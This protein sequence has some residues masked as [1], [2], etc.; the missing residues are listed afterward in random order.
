MDT[1]WA[2]AAAQLLAATLDFQLPDVTPQ[3]T[4][5]QLQVVLA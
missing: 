2:A 5:P 3:Q 1:S 4:T